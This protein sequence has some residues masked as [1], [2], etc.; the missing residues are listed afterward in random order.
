[1]AKGDL[2]LI[3]I[4]DDDGAIVGM[5]TERDLARR[6]VQESRE[7]SSFADRPASVE[8]IVEV[9]G[10]E[11]VVAPRAPPRRPPLGRHRGRGEHGQHDGPERHRRDRQPRRRPAARRSSSA[12]P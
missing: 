9:L 11:L 7:P 1:M 2:E 6:Y 3:P 8:L 10:G 4:V 5:L 12:S